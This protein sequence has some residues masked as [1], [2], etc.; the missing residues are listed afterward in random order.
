MIGKNNGEAMIK[1]LLKKLDKTIDSIYRPFAEWLISLNN[2]EDID[3][4]NMHNNIVRDKN[5]QK[6]NKHK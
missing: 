2:K 6:S 5:E 4:L 1:N 3:W